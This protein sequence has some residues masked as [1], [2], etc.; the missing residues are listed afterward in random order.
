MK[1]AQ[2]IAPGKVVVAEVP[3][4]V[5]GSPTDAVV[6]VV[7]AG[8]CGTDVRGFAGRPGPVQG[9]NC[10]HEF[11][12]VVTDV[13]AEVTSVRPGD[14]VLAPFTFSDG[15]CPPCRRGVPTSCSAGGMWGVAAGGG[16]AEAVLVPFADAT[17]VAV[18]VDENDE[19]IPALLTMT[20]V[21]S[22]GWHALSQGLRQV[23]PDRSTAV[24]VVGDGAV[25]L[26]SVLAARAAG[27]ERIFLLG[28]HEPRLAL[29][30][31]FGATDVITAGSGAEAAAAVR[32][33]TGGAGADLVVDAVGEQ[34]ALDT[35]MAACADGGVLG[36]VGGPHGQVDAAMCFLRNITLTGGITPARRYLPELAARV[37]AG[38]LDPSPLFDRTVALDDVGAGYAAMAG[39]AAVKVL[40]RP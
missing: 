37:I 30:T 24:A 38:E 5:P 17:L 4:P 33:A 19:R 31:R 23:P 10:G 3:D 11:A 14:F 32:E 13:G 29:G 28:H 26:G 9:P 34:S 20:D 25:G 15:V 40:V 35:A 12:G 7:A 39:R 16:Q 27:V 36:L 2:L 18:R 8:I 22:T 6:R 21:V 1:A